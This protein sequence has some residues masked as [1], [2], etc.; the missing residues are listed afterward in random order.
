ML[1]DSANSWSKDKYPTLESQFEYYA[2]LQLA[3]TT[4]LIDKYHAEDAPAVVKTRNAEQALDNYKN[5]IQSQADI[6]LT[7]VE[8]IL[9]W[10]TECFRRGNH[11]VYQEDW[12]FTW[13]TS[14]ALPIIGQVVESTTLKK[15]DTLVGDYLG[16]KNSIVIRLY[17]R[18]MDRVLGGDIRGYYMGMYLSSGSK[19]GPRVTELVTPQIITTTYPSQGD[20]SCIHGGSDYTAQFARYRFDNL[21]PGVYYINDTRSSWRTISVCT[22][23]VTGKYTYIPM[24]NPKLY[25]YFN[26]TSEDPYHNQL[27]VGWQSE[28]VKD[29][30]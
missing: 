18:D 13:K 30:K 15:A 26:V 27:F 6:F 23:I 17:N 21:E 20:G 28:T 2:S 11:P 24:I 29:R 8:S 9:A 7:S 22:N 1:K 25:N 16:L 3:G 12:S 14:S 5:R 19:D 4:A 10:H